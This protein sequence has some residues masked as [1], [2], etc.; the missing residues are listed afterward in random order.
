MTLFWLAIAVLLLVAMVFVFWPWF[1]F[2]GTVTPEV[3]LGSTELMA[4]NVR[5]FREHLAELDA[6]LADGRIDQHQYAQLKLERER[7]L[8][9]T[10]AEL[11]KQVRR[12]SASA[13]ALLFVGIAGL[14]LLAAAA[15]YWRL[16]ASE[17][18]RIQ[19]LQLD[20][21]YFDYQ[22]MLA[23]RQPDP[24]RAKAV[25][26][27]IEQRLLAEP[28]NI[29][30]WFVLARSCMEIGDFAKAAH[31][32]QEVLS[33]DGKSGM[34]MAEA[35]Q[36]IFLRDG[37][38]ISPPVVD[39]TKGALALEPENTMAL[40]LMGIIEFNQKNY[41]SAIKN[42]QKAITLLGP[43]AS[44][45]ESLEAGIAR[46]KNIYLADGGTQEQ[47]DQLLA[48][49]QISLMVELAGG[50]KVSPD[51]LVYV[52]ARA[53]QGAKI[54]LAITRIKVSSLPAKVT[55]TEAMAM[56]P[57]ASLANAVTIELVAR[58]SEDGSANAKPGDWQGNSGP[59][60]M[61]KLPGD[62]KLTIDHQ[63]SD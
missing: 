60:D 42:W 26:A 56:S 14:L 52:Y 31:A 11:S 49:R 38:Q 62:I 61:A 47:L 8:L 4:E 44:G 30:Y 16:G 50:V 15:G 39:L 10:D 5:L 37:N 63:L 28:N 46:A 6:Q 24:A 19:A 2:S 43:N 1:K 3:A 12:N 18:V 35:A 33:R 25:V 54:P 55:L 41:P 29:Q 53:W 17:D 32:Y 21:Q 40:G 59:L 23:N 58:V 9:E 36:A 34:I 13:G 22:D 7:A 27:A 20:K 57:M 51:Q 48:G 45:T